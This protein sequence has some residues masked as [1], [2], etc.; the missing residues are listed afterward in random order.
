MY[1]L[2][3]F[4]VGILNDMAKE[5]APYDAAIAAEAANNLSAAVN[6][7]QSQFWPPG[8]DS[9]ADGNAKT[10]ALPAIWETFPK[11]NEKSEALKSAVA[12]LVPVAGNGLDALKG[13]MGDV[14]GSCKGCHDDFRAK[15]R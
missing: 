7:G 13:A 9:E 14:G 6:L 8:S 10:R 4:N 12:A 1:Q 15:K 5:K 3:N 11:I 2:Y